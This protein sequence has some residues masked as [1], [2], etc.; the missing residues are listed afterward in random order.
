M[1]AGQLFFTSVCVE[2]LSWVRYR[3]EHLRRWW[4]YAERVAR[5]AKDLPPGAEVYVIGGVAEGRVT[6]LSDIDALV[7]VPGGTP[8]SEE[9]KRLPVDILLR[10]VDLYG[11]PVEV[12]VADARTL[13]LYG[14][15]CRV[16]VRV[17]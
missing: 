15:T 16:A 17:G 7:A 1:G 6:V 12:H 11:R 5:A 14:K 9:L 4:E 13:K 8:S 2:V 10:A 3:F